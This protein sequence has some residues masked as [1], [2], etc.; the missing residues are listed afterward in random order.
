M[1][2]EITSAAMRAQEKTLDALDQILSR[3]EN[4][5]HEIDIIEADALEESEWY[6]T[7]RPE[8][9]KMLRELAENSLRRAPRHRGPHLLRLKVCD[10]DSALC[11]RKAAM[12]PLRVLLEND[13]SDGALVRA[14]LRT[15]AKSGT[16]ELCFGA[17]SRL[18]PPAFEMESRGGHGELLKRL[19]V[20]LDEAVA[21]GRPPRLV[22]VADSDGE[23]PGDVKPH[24]VKI[25]ERCR[26]SAVPCPPL[27]KRTAE[28]YLPD[29]AWKNWAADPNRAS[30]RDR[31][32]AL[33]SL[34][35]EQRDHVAMA[36]RGKEPW[37]ADIP[38]VV[39]LFRNVSG[40]CQKRLKEADLKGQGETMMMQLLDDY[41][42]DLTPADFIGRDSQGD[43]VDVA[44]EIEDGL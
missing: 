12:T 40:E 44:R 39:D 11:A 43:L 32:T 13:V 5:V 20:R 28:N 19:D 18:V 41:A 29:I 9:R 26:R 3:V 33:L 38:E 42:L 21:S 8:K 31:V 16:F 2:F 25:R 10:D 4:D 35:P 1:L 7:S 15:F 27:N 24:A 37:N 14:A 22:V 34:T 6:R 17:P 23:W 36:T 30:A